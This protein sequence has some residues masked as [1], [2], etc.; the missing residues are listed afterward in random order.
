MDSTC[1]HRAPQRPAA[2]PQRA[3]RGE[4]CTTGVGV[5][6]RGWLRRE[7]GEYEPQGLRVVPVQRHE[8][9]EQRR[10]EN[11]PEP[12]LRGAEV[13]PRAERGDEHRDEERQA[14][15]ALVHQ[16]REECVMRGTVASELWLHGVAE[17]SRS[18]SQYLVLG[19]HL[20]PCP[21]DVAPTADVTALQVACGRREAL[22]R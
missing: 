3:G 2:G 17:A 7:H 5:S 10:K 19:E 6:Q 4:C 21:P 11:K 14:D 18:H 13:L 22:P 15:Y 8:P 9:D 20:Q 12:R 1:S 16:Y